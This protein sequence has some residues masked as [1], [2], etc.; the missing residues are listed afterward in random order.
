MRTGNRS[1]YTSIKNG[2]ICVAWGS[3]IFARAPIDC[4]YYWI[5]NYFKDT[6]A[7][8]ISLSSAQDI[9]V[10]LLFKKFVFVL[11]YVAYCG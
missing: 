9:T 11:A 7:L 1:T 3:P 2:N 4:N 10:L 5:L 8:Q 6:A